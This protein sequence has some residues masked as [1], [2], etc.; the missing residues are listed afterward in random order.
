M[1]STHLTRLAE[2]RL[3]KVFVGILVLGREGGQFPHPQSRPWSGK[4]PLEVGYCFRR[5]HHCRLRRPA[6]APG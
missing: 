3:G 2:V 6:A 4:L 1:L 5:R